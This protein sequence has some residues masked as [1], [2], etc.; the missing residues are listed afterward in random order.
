MTG[1]KRSNSVAFRRL[2]VTYRRSLLNTCLHKWEDKV[3]GVV[4]DVGGI[5]NN[6]VGF[7]ASASSNV[8]RWIYLNVCSA[9]SPDILADGAQVPVVRGAIDTVICLETLE[10]VSDPGQVMCEL[11]RVLRPAGVL[12][13]SVPFLMR[14]HSAPNDFWRFTEYQIRRMA[15]ENGLQIIQ[16]ERLGLLFTVLCDMTKQAISEIRWAALRWAVGLL[17]LPVAALVISLESLWRRKHSPALA[18]FTTGYLLVAV[19]PQA[20]SPQGQGC[21]KT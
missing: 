18:T 15:K 19:K 2:S 10:H 13:L 17:F 5:K 8:R 20:P 3:G 1:R 16:L 4:L 21:T 6:P 12:L 14:I 7:T 9:H 11:S